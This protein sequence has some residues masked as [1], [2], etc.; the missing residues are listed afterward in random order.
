MIKNLRIHDQTLFF[1]GSTGVLS[2]IFLTN[3]FGENTLFLL[4]CL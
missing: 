1:L 2:G 3:I 4:F